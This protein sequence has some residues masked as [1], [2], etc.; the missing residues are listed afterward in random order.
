MKRNYLAKPV[1]IFI[2]IAIFI[3]VLIVIIRS[4]SADNKVF[5]VTVSL[6]E[7][8]K[9]SAL[10]LEEALWERQS[11][12]RYRDKPLKLSDISQL[13]WAGQGVTRDGFYR[14][15]PSAG[16][17]YPIELYLIAGN[18]EGLRDGIY[19]YDPRKHLLIGVREGDHRRDLCAAALGQDPIRNAAA[20][21]VIGAVYARTTGKYRE[22]GV[23]YVHIEVGHVAQ[24]ISLQA[25]SL[26][27]GTVD[28]GAFHDDEVKL[29]IGMTSEE[30]LCIMPLGVR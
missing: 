10:S 19:R 6:P 4:K 2:L 18:V 30:P 25:V 29:I 23:R 13:L 21:I 24:N 9:K 8:A 15:A 3:V 12:R 28:I 1:A 16:A 26:G 7:P 14:T 20:V 17:L 11:V 22:R 5:Q 27:I